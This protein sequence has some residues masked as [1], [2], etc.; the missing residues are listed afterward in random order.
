MRLT[1]V[2]EEYSE[3]RSL[4]LIIHLRESSS[5]RIYKGMILE[6]KD[7]QIIEQSYNK[8]MYVVLEELQNFLKHRE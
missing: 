5:Q 3:D 8:N 7:N 1:K 4:K 6:V 2:H